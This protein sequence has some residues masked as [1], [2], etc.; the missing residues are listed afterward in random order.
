MTK[1]KLRYVKGSKEVSK[2]LGYDAR[3]WDI[4]EPKLPEYS[5]LTSRYPTLSREPLLELLKRKGLAQ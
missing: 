3:M 5:S 2:S 1:L 4:L